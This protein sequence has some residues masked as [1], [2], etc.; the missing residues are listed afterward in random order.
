[1]GVLWVAVGQWR[2]E[3][4]GGNQTERESNSGEKR[5]NETGRR[6]KANIIISQG[7]Q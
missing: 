6:P 4:E 3:R 7:L 5:K 2:S 1:L